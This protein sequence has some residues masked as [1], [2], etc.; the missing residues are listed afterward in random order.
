MGYSAGGSTLAIWL[1]HC[2]HSQR[3]QKSSTQ[4]KPPFSR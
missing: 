4:R 2:S 1:S 3:P